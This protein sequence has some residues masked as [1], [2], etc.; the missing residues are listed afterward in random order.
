MVLDRTPERFQPINV[1][2]IHIAM[3]RDVARSINL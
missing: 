3:M 2:V 1:G